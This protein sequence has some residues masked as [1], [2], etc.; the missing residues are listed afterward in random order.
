MLNERFSPLKLFHAHILF[1][2]VPAGLAQVGGGV[3]LL[4][5]GL[6]R[7]L[8]RSLC[9]IPLLLLCCWARTR[10][11]SLSALDFIFLGSALPHLLLGLLQ[12]LPLGSAGPRP[13]CMSDSTVEQLR[14]QVQQLLIRVDIIERNLVDLER[15]QH[16]AHKDIELVSAAPRASSPSRTSSAYIS[17]ASEIPGF[18]SAALRLCGCG[19]LW[20]GKLSFK[21]RASGRP[22]AGVV[23]C[24]RGGSASLDLPLLVKWQIPRTWSFERRVSQSRCEWRK[25]RTIGHYFTGSTSISHGFAAQKGEAKV[26][27]LGVGIPYPEKIYHLDA[28]VPIVQEN[29]EL[30]RFSGRRILT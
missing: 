8:W 12:D 17:L 14:L 19:S 5:T 20:G 4:G 2:R 13:I 29:V 22:E 6:S 11:L 16:G 23:S 10:P 24:L 9:H 26:Y 1:H 18:S 28:I 7:S 15:G 25:H 27:C 3:E 30:F 21:Q